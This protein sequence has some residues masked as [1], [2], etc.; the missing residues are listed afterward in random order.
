MDNKFIELIYHNFRTFFLFNFLFA[1]SN[2]TKFLTPILQ[3]KQVYNQHIPEED[4][5]K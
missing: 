1:F 3:K 5:H 2:L 4:K